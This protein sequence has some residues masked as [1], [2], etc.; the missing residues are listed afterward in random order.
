MDVGRSRA[1][2]MIC[3]AV[4]CPCPCTAVQVPPAAAE[5][6]AQEMVSQGDLA[7]DCPICMDSMDRD[8]GSV[9]ACG[10]AFCLECIRE[11]IKVRRWRCAPVRTCPGLKCRA[12]RD[13]AAYRGHVRGRPSS[14]PSMPRQ[15]WSGAALSASTPAAAATRRRA[16][17]CGSGRPSWRLGG[18]CGA[19]AVDEDA[20]REAGCGRDAISGSDTQ[21]P[22]LLVLHQLPR[23]P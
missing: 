15:C 21:G 11:H 13:C 2:L 5:E 12:H 4:P 10:H 14:V 9:T 22:R 6:R 16:P 3:S 8:S 18:R 1:D 7:D 20:A 23:S 17:G 19:A